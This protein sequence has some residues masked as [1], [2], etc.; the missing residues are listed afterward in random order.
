MDDNG[1]LLV[2]MSLSNFAVKHRFRVI[3]SSPI[4]SH[5]N[6]LVENSIQIIK[7]L[8]QKTEKSDWSIFS[9]V[10][11]QSDTKEV[12]VVICWQFVQQKT[13]KTSKPALL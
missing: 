5:S 10:K 3:A 12:G 8:L 4:Y 2:G 11:L 7:S 9:T 6:G 1:A 13:E